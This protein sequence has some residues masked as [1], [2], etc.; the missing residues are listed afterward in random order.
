MAA[1]S[2]LR[3]GRGKLF[4]DRQLWRDTLRLGL[5][6][7]N[8]WRRNLTTLA[9]AG[10]LGGVLNVARLGRW[11]DD[12]SHPEWRD[13]R[14]KTPTFI[15]AP[16]RS[17][18][19]F[20]HRLMALDSDF[21]HVR[22]GD[23]LFPS[24]TT[25]RGIDAL[26]TSNGL[27]AR[28]FRSGLN[29]L[30]Q[31]YLSGWD[32]V[33][34]TRFFSPE[35]D[36]GLYMLS[37][38]S[39]GLY[40]FVPEVEQVSRVDALDDLEPET[41]ERVMDYYESSLKRLL[42]VRGADKIFLG[43]SVFLPGRIRSL[44]SRFPDA[45]FIHLVRTPLETVPSFISMFRKPWYAHSPSIPDE[46]PNTQALMNVVLDGY[47]RMQVAQNEIGDERVF[48]LRF[49]EI[50]QHPVDSVLR[51]YDWLERS[52]TPE[53]RHR[54]EE[55]GEEVR[56]YRSKHTYSLEQYGLT[57]DDVKSALGA[58]YEAYGFEG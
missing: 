50:T 51:V 31:R 21:I 4:I 13:V 23:T 55:A 12:R 10:G 28:L 44:L 22:L 33:H 35:E 39:P 27:A 30:E 36:E 25:I 32:D 47:R 24:A 58:A 7:R 40:L 3:R 45:R 38:I 26:E 54:L 43:K 14:V 1:P 37:F 53:F 52:P 19:T 42:Y 57:K 5:D 29:A 18:T 20:F 9:V 41:R 11:W 46:H 6:P 56:S 2:R 34:Y 17:G 8:G 49:D 16:P 48:T 15:I